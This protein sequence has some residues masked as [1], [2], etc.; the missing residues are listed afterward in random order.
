MSD[1]RPIPEGF[2]I[3]KVEEKEDRVT[4]VID[5]DIDLWRSSGLNGEKLSLDD[6][7]ISC[8]GI[9]AAKL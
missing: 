9:E 7:F 2:E 5:G 3:W 1:T 8:V 6:I 4:A